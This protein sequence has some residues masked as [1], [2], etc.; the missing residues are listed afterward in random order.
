MV[1]SIS[2]AGARPKIAVVQSV[3]VGP[4][5]VAFE[6]LK[7]ACQ[8][9][10]QR[11][12]MSEMEGADIGKMIRADRP[13]VILAI[14]TDAV[15]SVKAITDIPVVYLMVFDV[16][17][18]LSGEG[19][20]TGVSMNISPERQLAAILEALP[21]TGHVGL[22]YDPEK[23]GRLVKKARAAAGPLKVEIISEEVHDFRDVSSALIKMKGKVDIFWMLPDVTVV[24]PETVETLLLFSLEYDI[25]VVT[26]SEKFAEM[27][28]FMSI[29]TD[30][31]DM[32]VQAGE[33]AREILSGGPVKDVPRVDAR[34]AVIS[35]N[36][37]IA[38][39]L[40]KQVPREILNKAKRIE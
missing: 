21:D 6:G 10:I 25:P 4:Y 32:G 19:H 7:S 28:A 17:A 34:T 20:I 14:G 35:I 40:E 2:P 22:L 11:M 16:E 30:A 29:G 39:K 9:V 23:T 5:D 24:T 27:G 33:M 15:S 18:A 38:R 13:D 31:F 36:L 26:F 8:S 37:K 3:R 1:L 12:V